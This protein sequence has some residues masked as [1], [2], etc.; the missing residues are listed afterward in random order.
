MS[1]VMAEVDEYEKKIR[2]HLSRLVDRQNV[3]FAY[4]GA[5][6]K[7]DHRLVLTLYY[8]TGERLTW[9]QVA[10]KMALSEQRIYQLHNDAIDELEK[11]WSE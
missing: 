9:H 8:L 2:D 1:R 10:E 5:L 4:I 6:E 11:N 7:S 3:A